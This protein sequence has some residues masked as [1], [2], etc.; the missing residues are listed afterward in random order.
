MTSFLFFLICLSKRTAVVVLQ[1][2]VL[3]S[4]VSPLQLGSSFSVRLL[5]GKLVMWCSSQ[6]LSGPRSQSSYRTLVQTGCLQSQPPV[7]RLRSASHSR[8]NGFSDGQPDNFSDAATAGAD[9]PPNAND[10]AL[11]DTP[12]K[13]MLPLSVRYPWYKSSLS[14][15]DRK[16]FRRM[17]DEQRSWVKS[18]AAPG[19]SSRTATYPLP[20]YACV[21][22][23]KPLLA[24]VVA[25]LALPPTPGM[26]PSGPLPWSQTKRLQVFLL[27]HPLYKDKCPRIPF[28]DEIT[29]Y[30]DIGAELEKRGISKVGLPMKDFD[31]LPFD[32]I[33]IDSEEKATND[34][35]VI[36][37]ND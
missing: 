13:L 12:P 32:V 10:N 19:A 8:D 18:W 9:L 3:M 17:S 22:P 26:K 11:V 4:L 28:K 27:T 34:P 31:T 5:L 30:E 21:K 24:R 33:D 20:A 1:V 36:V 15:I 2:L 29:E 14:P 7:K 35:Y 16:I 37:I 23:R 6:I 25:P